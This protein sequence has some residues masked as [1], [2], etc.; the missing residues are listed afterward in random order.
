[1]DVVGPI[2]GQGLADVVLCL[3][4]GAGGQHDGNPGC[5]GTVV[6][7]IISQRRDDAGKLR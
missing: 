4:A 3:V 2:G 6:D 1:M 7:E 5:H